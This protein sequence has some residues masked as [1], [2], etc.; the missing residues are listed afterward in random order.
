MGDLGLNLIVLVLLGVANGAPIFAKALLKDRF[1]APLD[2]GRTLPDRQPVF[3]SSKTFRGVAVSIACTAVAA[4][5]L[6][7][8]LRT[9]AEIAA[10]SMLGDVVSSFLKRRLRLPAQAQ[11]FGID[12]IPEALLPLLVLRTRLN[13]TGWDIAVLLAAFVLLEIWV[14]RLLFRLHIRDRPY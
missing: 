2:F 3:G 6:G 8:G 4:F 13:L 1:A 11:A 12:Q 5:V 10:L 14:S 9:G 7:V